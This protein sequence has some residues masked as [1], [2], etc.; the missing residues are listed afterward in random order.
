MNSVLNPPNVR[1]FASAVQ[2][3]TLA[4]LVSLPGHSARAEEWRLIYAVTHEQTARDPQGV[5]PKQETR[6]STLTL[7]LGREYLVVDDGHEKK[8]YDFA[9]RRLVQAN[10]DQREFDDWSLYCAIGARV[11]ELQNRFALGAGFRAAKIVAPEDFGRFDNETNLRLELPGM[12][13]DEPEPDIGRKDLPGGGWDFQHDGLSVV[14]FIPAETPVP[15]EFYSRFA[16]FLT[17]E[18]S[19]HPKIRRQV[20]TTGRIPQQLMVRWHEVNTRTI[21]T[22]RLQSAEL[23]ITDSTILP[24]GFRPAPHQGEPL[25]QAVSLVREEGRTT[26]RT[27]REEAGH[28]AKD[29]LAAKRPLDAYLALIEYMLQSGER[30][31]GEL[32]R[33]QPEFHQ[34]NRCQRYIASLDQSSKE[35]CRKSLA[36]CESI[37]RNGLQK[38]YMLDLQRADLLQKLGRGDGGMTSPDEQNQTMATQKL[39]LTV[40]GANPFLA[41]A[42]HDLGVLYYETY[43]HPLAW[44][45]FD[46]GRQLSPDHFLLKEITDLEQRFQHD[47]PDYF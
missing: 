46:T 14:Q 5:A 39:F 26:H 31:P 2:A 44:L 36:S 29:A 25:F 34:D 17:Y 30:K 12:K 28:F 15:A 33:Y 8:I 43:R 21:A 19:M 35:A 16:S 47:F 9:H 37:D 38:A 27:T 24:G 13:L 23:A 1:R 18:C 3:F 32:S 6:T 7:A 45:C 40:L 10:L 22:Y 41:G 20:V 11:S 4:T 42:Y